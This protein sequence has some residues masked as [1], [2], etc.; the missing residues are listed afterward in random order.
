MILAM[1][2]M[3]KSIIIE[4]TTAPTEE[5]LGLLNESK[6]LL[7][8]GGTIEIV[9]PT[10]MHIVSFEKEGQSQEQALAESKIGQMLRTAGFNGTI[11]ITRRGH[12]G[13]EAT[14]IITAV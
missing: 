14:H 11:S 13:G 12:I 4:L 7:G 1:N 9:S 5:L 3:I 2:S 6:K 10:K 8:K